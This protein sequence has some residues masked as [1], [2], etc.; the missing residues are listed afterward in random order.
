MVA[1]NDAPLGTAFTVSV[2]ARH[3]LTTGISAEQ[4][5]NTVRALANGKWGPPT[6]RGRAM[7]FR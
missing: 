6:S 2:D 4:R 5:C 1:Q 7:C 3:G